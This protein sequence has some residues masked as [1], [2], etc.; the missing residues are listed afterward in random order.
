MTPNGM[1]GAGVAQL[2]KRLVY[3]VD[4]RGIRI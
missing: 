1:V 4:N 3:E 2:I